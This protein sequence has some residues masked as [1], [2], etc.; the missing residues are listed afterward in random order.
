MSPGLSVNPLDG[1]TAIAW[2]LPVDPSDPA[3]ISV[4]DASS[5]ESMRGRALMSMST[6]DLMDLL[7]DE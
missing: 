6:D 4:K 3:Q 2:P 5:P 1:E 7:R